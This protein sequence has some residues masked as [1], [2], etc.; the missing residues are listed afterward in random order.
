MRGA[1]CERHEVEDIVVTRTALKK[2]SVCL[3]RLVY[4]FVSIAYLARAKNV[5]ASAITKQSGN[6]RA[7]PYCGGT[8]PLLLL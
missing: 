1:C 6:F 7:V 8:G 4:N 3:L 5:S 2:Q